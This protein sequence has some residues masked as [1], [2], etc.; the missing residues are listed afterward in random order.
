[1][2]TINLNLN[3]DY[4]NSDD[5][6]SY[7]EQFLNLFNLEEYDDKSILK[8][9]DEIYDILKKYEEYQSIIEILKKKYNLCGLLTDE[10]VYIVLYSFDYLD[11]FYDIIKRIVNNNLSEEDLVNFKNQINCE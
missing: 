3:L 6:I 4:K 10:N 7:Q 1:M 2:N 9:Q 11:M 8:I 5:N